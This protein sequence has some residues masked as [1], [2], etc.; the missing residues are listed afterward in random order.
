MDVVLEVFDTFLFD[1]LYANVLPISSAARALDP[2]STLS[3]SFKA[4]TNN[5]ASVVDSNNATWSVGPAG[6]H[7]SNG[8][9]WSP[10]SQY[11]SVEPSEYA[12]MSQLPRDNFYRQLISL[13]LLT[14]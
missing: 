4:A 9:Q 14:W 10:A 3:A 5:A 7:P 1:R 2:I 6:A 13:Y 8:W 12:Y 11:F